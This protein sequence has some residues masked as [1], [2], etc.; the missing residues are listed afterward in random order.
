[1]TRRIF[2]VK[3]GRKT[4]IFDKWIKCRRQVAG[5]PD[6]ECLPFKYRSE[7]VAEPEDV[8]G[9]LRYAVKKAKAFL[10]DLVYLGTSADYL[11]DAVWKSYGFL[12]FGKDASE[13]K[14]IMENLE[15]LQKP[16]D[17]WLADGAKKQEEPLEAWGRYTGA[18]WMPLGNWDDYLVA[19]EE[20]LGDWEDGVE[21]DDLLPESCEEKRQYWKIADVMRQCVECIRF[22]KSDAEKIKAADTLKTCLDH[23]ATDES[24]KDIAKIYRDHKAENAIGY[25]PPL[26]ARFVSMMVNRYPKPKRNKTKARTLTAAEKDTQAA[27][28]KLFDASNRHH[29]NALCKLLVQMVTRV[30]EPPAGVTLHAS[31]GDWEMRVNGRTVCIYTELDGS[32]GEEEDDGE[33][34]YCT[35][36]RDY[37]LV[38]SLV[39]G[40]P[41]LLSM[42]MRIIGDDGG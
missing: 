29:R 24:L 31:G 1:M 33:N 32:G 37:A 27:E 8:P 7:L 11:E 19:W 16:Y 21:A 39:N 23:C 20:S 26:A 18:R 12:P 6:A 9:S 22:S 10:G 14:R 4:G 28:E 15:D 13:A 5:Y 2:A 25:D 30:A 17:E 41:G 36:V 34:F 38:D 42:V 35:V 40:T 3:K